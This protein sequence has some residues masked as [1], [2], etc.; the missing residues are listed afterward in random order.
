MTLEKIEYLPLDKIVAAV[1]VRKE[2]S[3]DLIRGLM[4]SMLAVGQLVPIRVRKEGDLYVIVDGERRY[5]AMK[6]AGTFTTIAA[7]VEGQD[8]A[9]AAVQHR[10]LVANCQ[11]EGLTAME[12]ANAICELMRET[13][14]TAAE[15]ASKLGMSP[16]N[17]SKALALTELPSEIQSKIDAGEIPASAGYDL[18]RVKDPAQQAALAAQVARGLTRDALTGIV[19]GNG[20]GQKQTTGGKTARFKV[21]LPGG[22]SVTLV[23]AGLDNLETMIAW[24]EELVGKARKLRPK[25]V[26]LATFVRILRDEAKA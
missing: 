7:I 9:P 26:A 16:A 13:G 23:G 2:F 20:T 21:E 22:R 17:V 24:L 19:K 4:E 5:R 10:Q 18:S 3:E 15:V 6:M 14:W 1:Q 11:R 25:G 8:L 12:T